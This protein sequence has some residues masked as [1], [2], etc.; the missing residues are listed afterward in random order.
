MMIECA[1]AFASSATVESRYHDTLKVL[2]P[3]VVVPLLESFLVNLNNGPGFQVANIS[4]ARN[5]LHRS[6]SYGVVQKGL[7]SAW[8]S[9]AGG[10]LVA[11]REQSYQHNGANHGLL[12]LAK[13]LPG[14]SGSL[15]LEG[16]Q[17][18]IAAAATVGIFSSGPES[19]MEIPGESRGTAGARVCSSLA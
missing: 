9:M 10:R 19:K 12:V 4:F 3:A 6:N 17:K 5:G 16:M 18:T 8:V 13:T 2:Y 11:Q 14:A 15:A 7:L 1:S